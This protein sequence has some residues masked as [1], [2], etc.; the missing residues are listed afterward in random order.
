MKFSEEQVK[1]LLKEQR[2]LCAKSLCCIPRYQLMN[3]KKKAIKTRE[4]DLKLKE[5]KES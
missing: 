3:Q 1:Q 2:E 5:S 4:P